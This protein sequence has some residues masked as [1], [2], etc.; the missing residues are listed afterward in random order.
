MTIEFI[1][2][3]DK[4]TRLGD[5]FIRK[6]G[7]KFFHEEARRLLEKNELYKLFDYQ[8]IVEALFSKK[9][10][11]EQNFKS[12]EFS[13]LPITISR[14]E[15]CFIDIY[16]WRRR[17][18][19]IHNHHFCGAFQCISGSNLDLEYKFKVTR[20][21]TKFHALGELI[22]KRTK[23]IEAGDVVPINLL[24]KF[25]HQ[26]HH[27]ADLTVNLCFR[28]SEVHK[29]N[30]SNFLY[31]GLRYEKDP[32][33]LLR[34][35]RL[36]AL[37]RVQDFDYEKINIT[38]IDALNFLILNYGIKTQHPMFLK[39]QSYLDR[40]IKREFNLDIN[41]LLDVHEAELDERQISKFSIS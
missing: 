14:G 34:A 18:T 3:A 28:T 25:I 6:N 17:P 13:D 7:N 15:H 26:N 29:K 32:A 35:E 36:F 24:D 11:V 41:K 4:L 5:E 10:Q 20:K 23:K 40:R 39:L 31:S 16:F 27:L 37:T 9:F 1:K 8:E 22:H 19:T 2:Q 33:S 38:P 12:F 21:L 30:L